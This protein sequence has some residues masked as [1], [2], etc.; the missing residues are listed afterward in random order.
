MTDRPS[1]PASRLVGGGARVFAY[2]AAVALFWLLGVTVAAVVMRYLFNAPIL[3]ALDVS[4]MSLVVLV[5]LGLAHCG[6]KN[7]HV[8][9]DLLAM[10]AGRRLLRWTDFVVRLVAAALFGLI[11]VETARRALEARQWGEATNLVGIPHYPFVFVVAAGAGLYT[12][13]LLVQAWRI[14]RP[15]PPADES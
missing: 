5:F 6:W 11:T 13:V 9:V 4:E 8:F 1:D 14:A 12:L 15:L 7:G 10:L 2:G 3:G